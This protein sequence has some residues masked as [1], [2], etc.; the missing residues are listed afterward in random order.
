V[1]DPSNA[2]VRKA[3]L[4]YPAKYYASAKKVLSV[5]SATQLAESSVQQARA[6]A[7]RGARGASTGRSTF[8]NLVGYM[9]PG[10]EEPTFTEK[11]G[12]KLNMKGPD[13]WL[14]GMPKHS[15]LLMMWNCD[16]DSA[17]SF[18]SSTVQ[19]IWRDGDVAFLTRCYF[20][21]N[22]YNGNERTSI[23]VCGGSAV[24]RVLDHELVNLVNANASLPSEAAGRRLVHLAFD[25]ELSGTFVGGLLTD[26]ELPDMCVPRVTALCWL[27]LFRHA[28]GLWFGELGR[29]G[30]R[31]P[32]SI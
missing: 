13:V 23:M 2:T 31:A 25:H 1:V 15:W 17:M 10:C 20:E 30:G 26:A 6:S 28:L 27:C 21:T 5:R 16:V 12:K 9:P 4:E 18:M 8:F 22:I 24:A 29:V 7:P 3:Q 19:S 32:R 11:N 14:F